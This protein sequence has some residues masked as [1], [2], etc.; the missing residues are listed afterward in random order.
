MNGRRSF[1]VSSPSA[2]IWSPAY[3]HR[4][5]RID[6]RTCHITEIRGNDEFFMHFRGTGLD[7]GYETSSDPDSNSTVALR[8][9]RQVSV[10]RSSAET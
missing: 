7:A 9:V 8:T 2:D 10:G 1:D 4:P 3:V 6:G 5:P